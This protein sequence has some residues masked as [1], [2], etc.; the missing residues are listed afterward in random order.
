[1]GATP[2]LRIALT[3]PGVARPRR[4][5]HPADF[6]EP[7]TCGCRKGRVFRN[8]AALRDVAGPIRILSFTPSNTASRSGSSNWSTSPDIEETMPKILFPKSV[9]EE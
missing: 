2:A 4:S 6:F 8:Q 7:I 5:P 1:M 9:S 3:C